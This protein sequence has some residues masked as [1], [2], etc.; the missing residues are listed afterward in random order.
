MK[1]RQKSGLFCNKCLRMNKKTIVTNNNNNNVA[2]DFFGP[3]SPTS[4]NGNRFIFI[5]LA[6]CGCIARFTVVCQCV[7]VCVCMS[8]TQANGFELFNSASKP[9]VATKL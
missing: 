2:I 8:V 4:K 5:N 6:V 1:L 9:L 7:C 3:I